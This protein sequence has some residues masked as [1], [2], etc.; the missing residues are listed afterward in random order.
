MK[1]WMAMMLAAALLWAIPALA[2]LGAVDVQMEGETSHLVLDSV[3]IVDGQ[4]TVVMEGFGNTLRLSRL[5]HS[6][7]R[8][9]VNVVD[10]VVGLRDDGI[11][12][13]PC[14]VQTVGGT[15]LVEVGVGIDVVRVLGRDVVGT[16]V[17]HTVVGLVVEHIPYIVIQWCDGLRYGIVAGE[18]VVL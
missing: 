5:G 8:V 10:G 17:T 12:S 15:R 4:L 3:D 2:E 6:R 18:E 1:K 13:R 9:V 14:I 16:T 11:E 7:R